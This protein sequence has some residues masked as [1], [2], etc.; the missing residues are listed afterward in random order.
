MNSRF[1][2]YSKITKAD[3]RLVVGI[4]STATPDDQPGIWHGQKYDTDIVDTAALKEAVADWL[5]WANIREMHQPSAVGTAVKAT[6]KGDALEL[7]AK[8][9]DDDAW[10]KVKTK[11]YKGFSIGGRVLKAALEKLPDG[12]IARRILKLVLTEISLVDRP[13][14]REA[15]I[16][17]FKGVALMLN[18]EAVVAPIQEMRNASE[19]GGDTH[20][21]DLFTQAISLIVQAASGAAEPPE[22]EMMEG[23]EEETVL[24][25]AQSAPIW[26]AGRQLSTA[27]MAAMHKVVKALLELMS[28]AGDEKALKMVGVYDGKQAGAMGEFFKGG[29]AWGAFSQSVETMLKAI[30]PAL[31]GLG[32]QLTAMNGRLEKIEAQPLPGG[33][34]LM[35]VNKQLDPGL[36][37]AGPDDLA[38]AKALVQRAARVT[39]LRRLAA[40]EPNPALR[41]QYKAQLTAATSANGSGD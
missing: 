3:Q 41:D 9:E 16:M 33:P 32:E 26:K 34:A 18:V 21:T 29:P 38:K 23:E 28:G 15:I 14:N 39:E 40:T 11:V 27:N 24:M 17:T 2:R 22:I 36:T 7:A 31:D 30:N 10:K 19:M 4:A 37:A 20:A 12:R 8:I 5:Q 13:A 6:F 1:L 35:A 25:A